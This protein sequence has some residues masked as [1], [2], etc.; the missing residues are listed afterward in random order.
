MMQAVEREVAGSNVRLWMQ[1]EGAPLFYLHGFEQHPGA[2]GFL[3]K[4][5]E[6]RAL[7]A[8]EHPG[9]GG[10]G[11]FESLIDIS[12][13][14][15]H[16]RALIE[17]TAA[18]AGP[19]DL[20]G[21]SLGG[22][23]AAEI[24]AFCPDLVNRLVLVNPY[25]IWLDEAP[26]PDP[27]VIPA[28]ELNRAKWANPEDWSGN[29]PSSFP[30]GEATSYEGYRQQNLGAATKFMW[31]I[32]DRGLARRLRHIRAETLV[33]HGR[34]DGLIPVAYA[35]AFCRSI[36]DARQVIIE[37]AGHLPMIEAEDIFLSAV[38]DFLG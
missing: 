19:V 23:F 9:F 18:Q 30:S 37:R 1:G 34:Q 13:L 3:Q 36:P 16:Y 7:Y 2:A 4:L 24:A 26:L 25:G 28:A 12:D 15:L 11:G 33:I 27:F 6:R 8:P 32:P 38:E 5:G 20:I 31:P 14:V 35:E 29:E 10:S 21:H 17:A 22:M